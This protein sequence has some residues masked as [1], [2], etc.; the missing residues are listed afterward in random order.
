MFIENEILSIFTI[1]LCLL[2]VLLWG[3]LKYVYRMEKELVKSQ[4]EVR[5]LKDSLAWANKE[6]SKMV[7]RVTM[8]SRQR[9]RER[10]VN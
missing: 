1:G 9:K 3:L 6:N 2:A 4:R 5:R 7:T 8:L 10:R